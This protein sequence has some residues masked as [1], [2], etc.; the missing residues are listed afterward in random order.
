MSIKTKLLL[1]LILILGIF[2]NAYAKDVVVELMIDS[3]KAIIDN[4]LYLIDPEIKSLTVMMSNGTALVPIRFM[5]ETYGYTISWHDTAKAVTL[6][7]GKN[8]ISF[9]MDS[10]VMSVN[11]GGIIEMVR[12]NISPRNIEGRIY[13]PLREAAKALGQEQVV[14]FEEENYINISKDKTPGLTKAY[15]DSRVAMLEPSYEAAQFPRVTVADLKPDFIYDYTAKQLGICLDSAKQ[16]AS[17]KE[18]PDALSALAKGDTDIVFASYKCLDSKQF[19]SMNATLIARDAI[20]V[21]VNKDNAISNVSVKQIQDIYTG[22]M[23]YF[24][25]SSGNRIPGEIAPFQWNVTELSSAFMQSEVMQGKRMVKQEANKTITLPFVPNSS[26]PYY[27][28]IF[29]YALMSTNAHKSQSLKL[30]SVDNI[31]VNRFTITNGTY[32][33][34]FDIYAITR[35]NP[36][37]ATQHLIDYLLSDDGQVLIESTGLTPIK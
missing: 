36:T 7:Q 27:A 11:T 13:I 5:A 23:T 24:T 1:S 31:A 15:R 37:A 16:T 30:L 33:L 12:L 9:K 22:N 19:A 35:K 20:A 8:T 3:N 25:G 17:Q 21:F 2:A 32:P 26:S 6:T 18:I 29:G 28:N 34:S 4:Q 10:N 14:F